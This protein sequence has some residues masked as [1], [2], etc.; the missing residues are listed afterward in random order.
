[1]FIVVLTWPLPYVR[2]CMPHP[3]TYPLP[4]WTPGLQILNTLNCPCSISQKTRALGHSLQLHPLSAGSNLITLRNF[5]DQVFWGWMLGNWKPLEALSDKQATGG[6]GQN[7]TSSSS[8]NSLHPCK[9]NYCF[10]IR[11]HHTSWPG[12]SLISEMTWQP[13]IALTMKTSRPYK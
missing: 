12:L 3:V 11:S 1:M 5:K 8:H 9:K 6:W 2:L 13:P 7:V 4:P 10:R